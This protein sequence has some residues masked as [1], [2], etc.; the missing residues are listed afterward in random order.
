MGSIEA[1]DGYH[2]WR[3]HRKPGDFFQ[4]SPGGRRG[5]PRSFYRE[6]AKNGL[7]PN[8]IRVLGGIISAALAYA[9]RKGLVL[10]NVAENS[11]PPK[12]VRP[13]RTIWTAKETGRF[14]E[15]VEDDRLYA[16]WRLLVMTGLRRGE[17]CGLTW[18]NVDLK[19]GTIT[20]AQQ[21]VP[22]GGELVFLPPK[23]AAG[24]R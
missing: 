1:S 13:Q 5:K 20:V 16:L 15:A 9:K 8:T 23:T 11:D 19:V 10:H 17:A 6:A 12:A 4:A 24:L 3:D 21:L 18:F 14:L 2:G 7:K 22:V